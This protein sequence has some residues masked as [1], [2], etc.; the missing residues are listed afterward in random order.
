LIFRSDSNSEDLCGFA[1]A[2]LFESVTTDPA[3]TAGNVFSEDMLITDSSLRA[4]LLGRICV[5]A[6][7]VE[8]FFSDVPQDIEGVVTVNGELVVV[9]SRPQV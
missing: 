5:M 2:G 8:E 3:V 6:L 7:K 4:K 1:G 9:Q